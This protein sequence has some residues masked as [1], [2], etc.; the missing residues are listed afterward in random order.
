MVFEMVMRT[1]RQISFNPSRGYQY[2]SRHVVSGISHSET[3]C[4]AL[5]RNRFRHGYENKKKRIATTT[6][7]LVSRT[8]CNR[9]EIAPGDQ[10]A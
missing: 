2:L 8:A 4:K 5:S 3:L 1:L 9:D 7:G 10:N 6:P